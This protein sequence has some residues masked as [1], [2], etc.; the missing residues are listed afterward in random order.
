MRKI[1]SLLAISIAFYN[2]AQTDAVFTPGYYVVNSNADY[3]VLY[4]NQFDIDEIE[5]I[6]NIIRTFNQIQ[7]NKIKSVDMPEW[8]NFEAEFYQK[9]VLSMDG[10][11]GYYYLVDLEYSSDNNN[12]ILNKGEV[13]NV[14]EYNNNMFYCNTLNGS[15]LILKGQN[16]LSK[17]LKGAGIGKI[18]EQIDLIDG[19]T[20]N[21]GKYY[22]I[23][24]QNVANASVK[25]QIEDGKTIDVPQSKISFYSTEL[26]KKVN[27]LKFTKV[28]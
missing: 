4:S 16:S 12:Y 26:K 8:E 28:E 19:S 7:I 14:Y 20:I 9:K 5:G 6:S 1:L 15:K 25:I 21:E 27:D 10:D 11:G 22:W 24:S 17:V 13:L 2:I 23:I 3:S 18:I